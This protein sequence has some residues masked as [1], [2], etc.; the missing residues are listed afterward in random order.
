LGSRGRREPRWT[1]T[2]PLTSQSS[3]SIFPL[4]FIAAAKD[5]ELAPDKLSGRQRRFVMDEGSIET[6]WSYDLSQIEWWTR[7]LFIGAMGISAT[8]VDTALAD[9]LGP[10][11]DP[12]QTASL[13]SLDSARVIL[14]MVRNS[15][16]HRPMDP[17]WECRGSYLG[18]FSVPEISLTLDTRPL[19]QQP[20]IPKHLNGMIGYFKLVGFCYSSVQHMRK[21]SP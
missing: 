8:A 18:V 1:L 4:P 17:T 16:A 19:H 5:R 2:R 10:R 7:N 3:T 14:Y 13:S 6:E 12:A 15:F 20:L 11:P 9:L 21:P